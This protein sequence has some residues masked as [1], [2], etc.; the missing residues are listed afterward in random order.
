MVTTTNDGTDQSS[1][2]I[3][4]HQVIVSQIAPTQTTCSN[5]L[6]G[7]IPPLTTVQYSVKGG[8]I[9]QVNP[10]VLFYYVKVTATAGKNTFTINQAITTGNFSTFF[11]A[12]SSG[13]GVFTSTC[14]S[15][16]GAGF[17][18]GQSG[19]VTTITFTAPTAGTYILGVKYSTGNVVG[20]TA[21]TPSTTVHYTFTEDSHTNTTQGLD[22][23][24][25]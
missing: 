6:S 20:K 12:T 5:F 8:Q 2:S 24:Q 1:A 14:G 3:T 15:V 4:C 9:N 16:S 17:S 19:S 22:L 25:K 10:G 18:L 11:T 23:V 13:S 7:S 21:P